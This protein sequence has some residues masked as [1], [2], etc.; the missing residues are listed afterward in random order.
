MKITVIAQSEADFEDWSQE[1]VSGQKILPDSED[2]VAAE[3]G[4]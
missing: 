3:S 1:M 2:A 4:E